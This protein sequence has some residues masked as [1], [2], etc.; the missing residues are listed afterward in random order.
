[1]AWRVSQLQGWR[2]AA[3]AFGAGF[4]SVLAF[5]P[6]HLVF[7]LF[8]T[9]PVLVW[10]IDSAQGPRQAAVAGWWY[11]FGFFLFNLFWIGEAFLVEAEKFAWL[12]PVAVTLLPAG[13]AF[14]WAGAAALAKRFWRPGLERVLLLAVILTGIEWLRGHV[15]TG[16][17][18]NV[19]GYALTYPETWMQSASLV[20]VYALTLPAFLIFATPLVLLFDAARPSVL[21]VTKSVAAGVLPL[22]ALSLYGA[23][24][25][26]A[27]PVPLLEGVKMRIVQPSVPQREKWMAAKQAEI[28]K[29]HL[30]L[31]AT[32]VAGV[33]D[34]AAGIT[35]VIW[36]EAAMPFLPLEHPEALA[37][38]AQALPPGASLLSG[39]LRRDAGSAGRQR[40]FNSILAFD[41][42]GQV[43]ATYDKV[44]LVPFGEYLP[45]APVLGALGLSKLTQGLGVF[46]TGPW[47]RP[48][49]AVAGLPRAGGLICYEA[50]FPG[51]VVT[52]AER[53]G[54]LINVTND[55]WFG[56]TSGP[57][58]HFHQTRVRA[59]EEGVPI[60]RAAN[61]GISAMIDPYG[62]ILG[63][64]DLNVKGVIDTGLPEALPP[65]PYAQ[66]G[67]TGLLV[68]MLTALGWLSWRRR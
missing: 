54:L 5:A 39:A 6:W 37:A 65:G 9:L 22:M 29:L 46:D 38:I 52:A 25:L 20:G 44:H 50:L 48:P 4:L 14:F 1:M 59:V 60:V 34:E 36:P 47:P 27:G 11:G 51:Q 8:L 30:D 40:G 24:R 41:S 3:V 23:W 49:L 12:M 63:F 19:L 13:L 66:A 67:D 16:L 68:L 28:F 43:T 33:R 58:Q 45:L 64:A 55:G 57:R 7:V 56:D 10:I 2:R 31:T 15:L 18:W 35:H 62:R 26:P 21:L 42:D 17:P 32:S 53:P 61:N